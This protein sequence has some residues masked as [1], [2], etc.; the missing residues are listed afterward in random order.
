[1]IRH[2]I[3]EIVRQST[4]ADVFEAHGLP[5]RKRGPC[6]VCGTSS[7]SKA[8]SSKNEKWRCFACGAGG[9]VITLEMRLSGSSFGGAVEAL[10]ARLG[11]APGDPA[12]LDASREWARKRSSSKQ[13]TEQIE[14]G[15]F[16]AYARRCELYR[17]TI[18]E[19][20][21]RGPGPLVHDILA[22]LYEWLGRDER[23]LERQTDECRG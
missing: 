2:D 3:A 1:M 7:E 17:R 10:A 23:W 11:L 8:F 14:R 6:P 9:N 5:P 22:N 4:L 21:R 20:S 12:A 16:Q 13:I 15:R 18:T 19:V